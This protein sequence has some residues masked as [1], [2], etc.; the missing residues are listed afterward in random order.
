M[1]DLRLLRDVRA[2][3]SSYHI[4]EEGEQEALCGED[5]S[6]YTYAI[7]NPTAVLKSGHEYIGELC[8]FCYQSYLDNHE[9]QRTS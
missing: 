8:T 6:N 9:Q 4:V 3:D 5:C 2:E 1:S 7:L